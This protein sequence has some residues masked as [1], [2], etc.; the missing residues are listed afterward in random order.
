METVTVKVPDIFGDM[1]FND[2][3]MK[4]KL[5]MDVY[6]KLKETID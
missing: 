3:A 5:P 6:L 1:V 4:D 2:A